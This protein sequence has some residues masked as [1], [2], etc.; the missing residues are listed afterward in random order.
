MASV[1]RR[2]L[3]ELDGEGPYRRPEVTPAKVRERI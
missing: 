1:I 3:D 2:A